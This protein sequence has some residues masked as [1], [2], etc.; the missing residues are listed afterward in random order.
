MREVNLSEP[1]EESYHNRRRGL[2][3]CAC[4]RG[5]MYD[6]VNIAH[7]CEDEEVKRDG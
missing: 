2:G 3:F 4:G 5:G 7:L 6:M 1:S